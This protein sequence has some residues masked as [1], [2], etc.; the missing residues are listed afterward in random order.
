MRLLKKNRRKDM[1]KN[2]PRKNFRQKN[3]KKEMPAP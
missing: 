2:L 3:K 1:R